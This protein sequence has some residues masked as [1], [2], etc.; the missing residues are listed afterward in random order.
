MKQNVGT[1]DK[2]IRLA[3]GVTAIWLAGT[4]RVS[5]TA[6]IIAI[7]VGVLMV[8]TATLRF[9]PLYRLLG[10]STNKPAADFRALL[11]EGAVII[12]VRSPAEFNTGHIKG[13]SNIPVGQLS[14]QISSLKGKTVITCCASGARSAAAKN[15]LQKSG[16]TAYNGGG[17]R[18]LSAWIG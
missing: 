18:D 2:L 7:I 5:G 8:L 14:A 1:T 15:V 12:D 17:W 10:I 11:A 3:I 13:S 4:H 16:I 6:E 9:C